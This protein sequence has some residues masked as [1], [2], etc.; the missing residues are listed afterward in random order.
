MMGERNAASTAPGSMTYQQKKFI[1]PLAE[2]LE[3]IRGPGS[4]DAI[5]FT[6]RPRPTDEAATAWSSPSMTIPRSGTRELFMLRGDPRF[7]WPHDV[8]VDANYAYYTD[9]F[10][11]V[12]GRLDRKT[13]VATELS[14][15]LPP[16]G[17]RD[18]AGGD[19]RA[20]NPGGGSHD[21]LFDREGRVVI[22]MD[23][24]TVRHDPGTGRFVHWTSG[25]NMF[26]LDPSGN[27]WHTDDGGPLVKIDTASGAN[28]G[29]Q[30]PDQ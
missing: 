7:V 3:S 4:S 14:Y 15:P 22:G 28:Q 30:D 11:Y 6:L 5:P 10:S 9:H 20:G 29:V 24:A 16:G 25:N 17:G 26:G 1:E 19:G 12:L 21:L 23:G 13:G 27:V 8:I 18:P 2:Y